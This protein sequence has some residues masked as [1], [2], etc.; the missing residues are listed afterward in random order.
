MKSPS[1][2]QL[3]KELTTLDRQ[4]I[5]DLCIKLAKY[6][7]ENK[8]L[9]SYLLYDV[10]NES[11]YIENV[12]ELIDSLFIEINRK[13]TYT[14]KKGLQKI[15]RNINRLLKYSGIRQTEVEIRIYF[16]KKMRSNRIS[17]DSSPIIKNL[18]YREK[19]KINAALLKLH[20]DVQYDY[21]D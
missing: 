8:E 4:Q 16:C 9:L 5:I 12:K 6:K 14:T 18:Y 20:E 3:Q 2:N 21:K 19:D 11:T 13:T 17:L 10:N 1:L 7:K 15:V